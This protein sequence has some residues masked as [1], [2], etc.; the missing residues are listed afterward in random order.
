MTRLAGFGRFVGI[1]GD[2]A[3]VELDPGP[4][5]KPVF[6]ESATYPSE[7][8]SS[9]QTILASFAHISSVSSS[10]TSP[11][12]D[13]QYASKNDDI[14]DLPSALT[15]ESRRFI[16]KSDCGLTPSVCVASGL[17]EVGLPVCRMVIVMLEEIFLSLSDGFP[18]TSH[19][20]GVCLCSPGPMCGREPAFLGLDL[21]AITWVERAV[22]EVG[23]WL[24][25]GDKDIDAVIPDLSLVTRRSPLAV[26][27]FEVIVD[28]DNEPA[29]YFGLCVDRWIS[30]MLFVLPL[31]T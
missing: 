3:H 24:S 7:A 11:I 29:G 25:T 31:G 28:C 23:N 16:I 1:S 13:R 15:P 14:T 26:S 21:A 30:S 6:G 20:M 27:S 18:W 12:S 5:S 9:A 8:V 4:S 17:Q 19:K 22:D 2:T 10:G